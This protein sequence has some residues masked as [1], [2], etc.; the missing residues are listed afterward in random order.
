MAEIDK[1]IEMLAAYILEQTKG[2][3][4][5]RPI[6]MDEWNHRIIDGAEVFVPQ[7]KLNTGFIV[8]RGGVQTFNLSDGPVEH[9]IRGLTSE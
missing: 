1:S 9:V 3:I 8:H 4:D 5:I 7:A 6:N 2:Q